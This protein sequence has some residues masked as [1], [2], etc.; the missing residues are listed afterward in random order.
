MYIAYLTLRSDG[1]SRFQPPPPQRFQG[2]S[3]PRPS[4]FGDK[5]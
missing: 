2:F 4:A 1:R 3:E 5:T